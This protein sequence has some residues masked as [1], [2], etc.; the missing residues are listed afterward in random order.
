M[1]IENIEDKHFEIVKGILNKYPFALDICFFEDIPNNLIIRL[2]E[3]FEESDL[4]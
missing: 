2:E 1:N 3:E 4:Q